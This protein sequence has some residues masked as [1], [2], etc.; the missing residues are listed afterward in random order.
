MLVI[1][2]DARIDQA[3]TQVIHPPQ[4]SITWLVTVVYEAGS[5]G[6][7]VGLVGLALLAR[8]WEVA[9]DLALSAVGA[10]AVSGILVLLLGSRGGR[11][12][13]ISRSMVTT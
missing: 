8:R 12:S 9:R 10:A 11:P 1:H 13:G 7:A 2:Y 4:Q 5:I 6:V 3:I